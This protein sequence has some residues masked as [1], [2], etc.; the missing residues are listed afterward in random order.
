MFSLDLVVR[1]LRLEEMMDMFTENVETCDITN[2][3]EGDEDGVSR[4]WQ[5]A[6]PHV[7]SPVEES[8]GGQSLVRPWQRLSTVSHSHILEDFRLQQKEMKILILKDPSREWK[9]CA[10][11]R[12][13]DHY[14]WLLRI[15]LLRNPR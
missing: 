15:N 12:W 14:C 4:Y 2:L 1:V 9:P 3:E 6:D 8:R 13:S 5:G 7:S 11:W 10:W